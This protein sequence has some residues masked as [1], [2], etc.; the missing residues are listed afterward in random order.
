MKWETQEV[1]QE[2]GGKKALYQ[3]LVD[4][5][6][7]HN[8]EQVVNIPTLGENILYLVFT[9]NKSGLNKVSSTLPPLGKADHDIIYAEVDISVHRPHKPVSKVFLYRKAKCGDL[10]SRLNPSFKQCALL[11]QNVLQITFGNN[12][13]TVIEGMNKYIPQNLFH[14]SIT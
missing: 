2:T 12:S 9:N 3:Q 5:S 8:L 10:K 13:R 4:I 7:D 11:I 6:L 1:K 14:L